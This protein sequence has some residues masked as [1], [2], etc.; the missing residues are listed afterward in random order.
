MPIFLRLSTELTVHPYGQ[1]KLMV[2]LSI[3]LISAK[4]KSTYEC[5]PIYVT[6]SLHAKEDVCRTKGVVN[7]KLNKLKQT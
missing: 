7:T 2:A 1:T 6:M 5:G 4:R 3:L